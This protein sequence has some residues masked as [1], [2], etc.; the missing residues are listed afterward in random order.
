MTSKFAQTEL[1]SGLGGGSDIWDQP[2]A[3]VVLDDDYF[4]TPAPAGSPYTLTVSPAAVTLSGGTVALRT[5]RKLPVASRS[6]ATTGQAVT[7]RYGRKAGVSSASAALS[8]GS[9]GLTYTPSVPAGSSQRDSDPIW[10]KFVPEIP[11]LA[12][13]EEVI[14]QEAAKPRPKS[15]KVKREVAKRIIDLTGLGGLLG[16]KIPPAVY[17]QVDRALSPTEQPNADQTLIY[18]AIRLAVIRAIEEDDEEDDMMALL[19][20]A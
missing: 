20:V 7:A 14:E 15:R 19:M 12:E 10:R 18:V 3:S 17:R 4:E 11:E 1:P 16:E 2:Q 8:G 5:A 9:V 6:I 13:I